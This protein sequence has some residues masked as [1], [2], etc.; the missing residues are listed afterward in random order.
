MQGE[1]QSGVKS[2]LFVWLIMK[3]E[4]KYKIVI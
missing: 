1:L 2:D 3:V 4:H